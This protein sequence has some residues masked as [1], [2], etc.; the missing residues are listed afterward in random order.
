MRQVVRVLLAALLLAGCAS[1][2]EAPVAPLA[3]EQVNVVLI[4]VDTLAARHVGYV[5]GGKSVT[6]VIDA[7]AARG[8]AFTGAIAP[9]P[10][11]QPSIG[12]LLTG[13]M[14]SA[15]RAI[16][17]FDVPEPGTQYL[18]SFLSSRGFATGLVVSHLLL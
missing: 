11:T 14:P 9:A 1:A 2:P 12:S 17:L 4:V 8:V 10:W 15:H 18:P 7:L 13:K 5:A 6:P 16:H 3:L